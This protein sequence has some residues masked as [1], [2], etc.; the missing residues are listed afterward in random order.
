MD[1]GQLSEL[2]SAEELTECYRRCLLLKETMKLRQ[3]G[4]GK[5]AFFDVLQSYKLPMSSIPKLY[6][7]WSRVDTRDDSVLTWGVQWAALGFEGGKGALPSPLRE[8][9]EI[10]MALESRARAEMVAR[11][12]VAALNH[13]TGLLVYARHAEQ[14]TS[15]AI[16]RARTQAALKRHGGAEIRAHLQYGGSVVAPHVI[17]D[18]RPETALG[19]VNS[20]RS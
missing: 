18:P 11:G 9:A 20:C 7:A 4:G 10:M 15:R 12:D 16:K 2:V 1:L 19:R 8:D 6:R 5:D 17:R 13:E 3:A 14:L